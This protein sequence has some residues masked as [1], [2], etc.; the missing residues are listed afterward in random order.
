MLLMAIVGGYSVG[1]AYG[2]L[3]KPEQIEA[4]KDHILQN[5]GLYQ[6]MIYGILIVLILDLIVSYTLYK[7]F[8]KDHKKMSLIS[9]LIRVGYTVVFGIATYHLAQNL[10]TDVLTNETAN[11]NFLRFETIWNSGLVV[12]G[13][14]IVL[15]GVLM[16]LHKRI[17]KILWYITLLAGV[18]YVVVHLLKLG[19]SNSEMVSNIE[20]ILALPM[21]L[22]ELGL[23]VWLL[24]KGGK[25]QH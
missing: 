10:N 1:Y 17:P 20:M 5:Q 4:L 18:S 2:E 21:A 22:G 19:S 24:I 25:K 11:A 7:Y 13:I 3:Y 9:G 6:G 15:I 23:A 14:H 16:K 12:F 8:E